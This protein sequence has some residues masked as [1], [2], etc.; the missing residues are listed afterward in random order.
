MK[1]ESEKFEKA[2]NEKAAADKAAADKAAAAKK[3]DDDDNAKESK[4]NRF[5]GLFH[6]DDGT[7]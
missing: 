1:V 7:R 3:K 6:N 5:T 2:A 4:L